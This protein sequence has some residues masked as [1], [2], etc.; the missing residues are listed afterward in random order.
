MI[1]SERKVTTMSVRPLIVC[2]AVLAGGL[3]PAL[4]VPG[5]LPIGPT[6][7]T[8][9]ASDAAYQT[10]LNTTVNVDAPAVDPDGGP[11]ALSWTIVSGP[12]NGSLHDRTNP[13][14][15]AT[16][17]G[18]AAYTPNAGYRGCDQFTFRVSDGSATS[19]T[20]TVGIAVDNQAPTATDVT[21]NAEAGRTTNITL[22]GSDPDNCPGAV[23]AVNLGTPT[24]GTLGTV[25]G[26][27]VP[28]TPNTG[29]VGTDTFTFQ[30]S[31]GA[32][33]SANTATATVN[34]SV[35]AG[36][37]RSIRLTLENQ[38]PNRYIHYHLHL[39]AFREDIPVGDESRYEAFGYEWFPA[40]VQFGCYNFSHARGLYYYYHEEG[41]FRANL[42][43]TNDSTNPVLSGI[44]PASP[45]S[46]SLDRFFADRVVP[47]PSLILFHDPGSSVPSQFNRLNRSNGISAL[48][49][50]VLA[51]APTCFA[52]SQPSWYYVTAADLPAG[53]IPGSC[54]G[55]SR[56]DIT[57]FLRFFRVPAETQDNVCGECAGLTTPFPAQD[58]SA[59]HWL[60]STA[61]NAAVYPNPAQ[62][63]SN[64]DCFE[65]F[66]G[67]QVRYVF[68][69]AGDILPT[70]ATPGPSLKWEV[71][72][73]SGDVIHGL[74]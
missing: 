2:A 68:T 29:F 5:C 26:L 73:T 70:T 25:S 69:N 33:T 11:G 47:V 38:D 74:R 66:I 51:C 39:I 35:S 60:Q 31:D 12:S 6:N 71:T 58:T 23:R 46:N 64:S 1:Q 52:C 62:T 7:Q 15:P 67:A 50:S 14:L 53:Q 41:R 8:P 54:A 36:S 27:T 22:A 21:R 40:G 4:L 19:N 72:T 30:V 3:A 61:V 17:P 45:S 37:S 57:R 13:A 18:N 55:A 63:P 10:A 59:A 28:Y 49:T 48:V 42:D 9:V 20:A 44:E 65:Y 43:N 16:F 34:V 56:T 24:N 32:A